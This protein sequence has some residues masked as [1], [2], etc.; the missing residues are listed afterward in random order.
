MIKRSGHREPWDR[1][2]VV[3]GL[4][5]AAKNRPLADALIDDIA[6]QVEEEVR[7]AGPE[8]TSEQVGLALLELHAATGASSQEWSLIVLP[9]EPSPRTT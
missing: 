4:H 9:L 2:K 7:L 5:A 8:V 1:A 6:L 3:A